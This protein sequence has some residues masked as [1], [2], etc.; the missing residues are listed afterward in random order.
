MPV[1]GNK[2]LVGSN[3][4]TLTIS[5]DGNILINRREKEHDV[6]LREFV[7]VNVSAEVDA[8]CKLVLKMQMPLVDLMDTLVKQNGGDEA[9]QLNARACVNEKGF[10]ELAFKLKYEQIQRRMKT[11]QYTQNN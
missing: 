3:P 6:S 4:C 10:K 1:S 7:D 11:L 2:F 8:L 9:A 5:E